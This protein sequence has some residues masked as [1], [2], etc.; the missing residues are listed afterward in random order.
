MPASDIKKIARIYATTKPACIVQ[1]INHLDQTAHGIQ[2][3]R[4]ISILQAITGNVN[5]PGGFVIY[6]FPRLTD[7]RIPVA[8]KPIGADE[9]PLFY[10]LWGRIAPYGQAMRM[11]DAIIEGKPYPVKV[12]IVMST[13]LV[14]TFLNA[15]RVKRG[16]RKT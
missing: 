3:S 12:M 4:A 5:R 13:N 15:N 2:T 16:P 1:G 10:N 14:A 8:E 9:F 7:L 6:P 11:L